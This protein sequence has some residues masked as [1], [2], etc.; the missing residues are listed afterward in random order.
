LLASGTWHEARPSGSCWLGIRGCTSAVPFVGVLSLVSSTLE[1]M[2]LAAH[3]GED[4]TLAP[5]RCLGAERNG[6]VDGYQALDLGCSRRMGIDPLLERVSMRN[7]WRLLWNLFY[8]NV[9][10]VFESITRPYF[11]GWRLHIPNVRL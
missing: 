6:H 2:A 10:S 4:G 8:R 5:G 7:P 11:E 3:V 1:W 9:S